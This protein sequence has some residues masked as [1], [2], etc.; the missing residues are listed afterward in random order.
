MHSV[1]LARERRRELE[2]AYPAVFALDGATLI[3]VCSRYFDA[4]PLP[5][6]PGSGADILGFGAFLR[7]SLGD[8][9]SLPAYSSELVRFV[10]VLQQ[11]RFSPGADEVAPVVAQR[12]V[13]LR[14]RPARIADVVL[15]RFSYNITEIEAALREGREPD[16][17]EQE[18]HVVYGRRHDD[19]EPVVL[20]VSAAAAVLVE[21]CDGS[22]TLGA[23]IA[24]ATPSCL[25]PVM[26]PAA[27]RAVDRL[28]GVG[29][30]EMR[31]AAAASEPR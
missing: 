26:A 3:A 29:I 11:V 7:E 22:Q 8:A 13:T 27:L 12:P 28:I 30:F 20:Q 14:D 2:A 24:G 4:Y 10:H 23:V 1:G 6:Q 19:G 18:V 9:H 5:E 17:R 25:R 21:Q 16:P 15:E 31:N